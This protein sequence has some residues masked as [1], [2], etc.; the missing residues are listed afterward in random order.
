MPNSVGNRLSRHQLDLVQNLAAQNVPGPTIAAIVD[1]M[2]AD[3]NYNP[4]TREPEV[5][6]AYRE[7]K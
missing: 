1:S 5:A 7:V 4:T 2:L 3:P 6:P